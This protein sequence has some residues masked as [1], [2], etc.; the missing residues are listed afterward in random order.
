[1]SPPFDL[2]AVGRP[3]VDVVF[4]GLGEWPS[5][6]KD[7]E[8]DGLGV[9][10]GTS[11]NTPAAANR[12]GLRVAYVATIGNDV[13]SRMIADEF[14][15]EELPEDFLRV[16]ERPLPGVSVA[17]NFQGDRGFV[18][19]WSDGYSDAELERRACEVLDEV[20]VRHLH[21]YADDVPELE[22]AAR[23]KGMTVS[24][25]SWGGPA[26]SS[27]RSLADVLA[28]ADVLFANE[29][30]AAAMSGERDLERAV[31]RLGE[32]CGC[33]VIKIGEG[34]ALGLE[35]GDVVRVDSERVPV[36]D[37]T[38]AGDCFNAGFLRGWLAG[39]PME[40]SLSLGVLCAGRAVAN[41]GAYRGCPREVELRE[42]A[43][44]R[45][46]VLGP[47]GGDRS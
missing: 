11:F 9:C 21:A 5:L 36:L 27:P 17:L 25:D 41:Y 13:W 24:V 20:T 46:I 29:A 3:S 2:L 42:L 37:A 14:R 10:A 26:W 28:N 35:H 23:A 38:G 19:R 44:A 4:T 43:A 40:A 30:E 16:E 45:G 32:H 8:A 47:M 6:G 33:V 1:M 15:A 31:T 34:G 18:T 22:A 12:L 7:V 39:L